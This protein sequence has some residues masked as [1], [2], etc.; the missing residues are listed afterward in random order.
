MC[1]YTTLAGKLPH[2]TEPGAESGRHIQYM[3]SA[4]QQKHTTS[5]EAARR[6]PAAGQ[7]GRAYMQH[8]GIHY[9]GM[10]PAAWYC[11]KGVWIKNL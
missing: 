7:A 10:F 4:S 5:P 11:G 2:A 9:V 8:G 1:H 3:V 6:R